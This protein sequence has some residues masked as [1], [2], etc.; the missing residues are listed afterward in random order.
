M[1]SLFL[2]LGIEVGYLSRSMIPVLPET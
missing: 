2:E 1:T